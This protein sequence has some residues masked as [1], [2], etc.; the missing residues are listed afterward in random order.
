[1]G[2]DILHYKNFNTLKARKRPSSDST[3]AS[4][5]GTNGHVAT[6]GL[7]KKKKKRGRPRI[8]P[9]PEEQETE[10]DEKNEPEPQTN[11]QEDQE[12]L[13]PRR[14]RPGCKCHP[15]STRNN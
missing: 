6:N 15:P 1:M 10:E 9:R 8:H 11:G 4:T 13:P 12:F 7:R 2:C 3:G 14:H 5:S